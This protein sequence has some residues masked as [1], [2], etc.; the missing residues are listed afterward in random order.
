MLTIDQLAILLLVI[1]FAF[2]AYVIASLW[3]HVKLDA[4]MKRLEG[5][6]AERSRS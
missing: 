6:V 2:V 3:I 5:Q 1:S 4:R